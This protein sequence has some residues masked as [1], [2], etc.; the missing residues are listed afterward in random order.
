MA[1]AC[2]GCEGPIGDE[3]V[4]R[5]SGGQPILVCRACC[6]CV[7]CKRIV[8]QGNGSYRL[9]PLPALHGR[10]L[11]EAVRRG[12]IVVVGGAPRLVDED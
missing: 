2:P 10:C 8:T 4:S 3:H 1:D 7:V 12:G 6:I 9:G 11:P 5:V